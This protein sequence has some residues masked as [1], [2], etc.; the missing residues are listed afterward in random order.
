[1]NLAL[2][3]DSPEEN[4]ETLHDFMYEGLNPILEKYK[5]KSEKTLRRLLAVNYLA[6]LQD[7]AYKRN[8]KKF[9]HTAP[10][11]DPEL[12]TD[13]ILADNWK[14]YK[15]IIDD[16]V[17][18]K[19]VNKASEYKYCIYDKAELSNMNSDR[20]VNRA[21]EKFGKEYPSNS[22]IIKIVK[23]LDPTLIYQTITDKPKTDEPKTDEPKTDTIPKKRNPFASR[24][25]TVIQFHREMEP[26]IPGSIS[27]EPVVEPTSIESRITRRSRSNSFTVSKGRKSRASRG[28]RRASKSRSRSLEPLYKS[29]GVK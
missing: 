28:S 20:L 22:D 17:I 12:I 19:C 29:K 2:D 7:K 1:M 9:V 14:D 16:I 27:Y 21:K 18:L 24:I 8:P 13:N 15:H 4:T 5:V 6:I 11:E 3:L 26:A 10:E 23:G 25:P